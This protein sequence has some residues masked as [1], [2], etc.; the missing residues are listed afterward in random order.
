M[1]LLKMFSGPLSW[2]S[3]LSSISILLR[4]GLFIVSWISWMF[5]VRRFFLGGEG[6][7]LFIYISNVIPFPRFPSRNPLFNP[8]SSYTTHSP[9]TTSLPWYSPAVGHWDSQDQGSL[10][11]LIYGK[12]ILCYICCWSHGSLHVYSLVSGLVPWSTAGG[13]RVWLV[14]FVLLPMGCTPLQFLQ[15]FLTPPLGNP[16]SVQ[17]LAASIYLCICHIL[18]ESLRR[19]LYQA[20]VS[21]HFLGS[22]IVSGFGICIWNRSP[23][24]AVS[25][26]PLLQSLLNTL[27][28]YFLPWLF[29][30][31]F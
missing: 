22:I 5:W 3:L 21:K 8:P 30:S 16:C 31:L 19:Q 26:W 24:G 14:D 15:S 9:T 20:P 1:I 2:E 7:I 4:F 11:P 12:A 6:S 27:S 18:A 25:R 10:L 17:W 13:G 28:P 29:C 23:D